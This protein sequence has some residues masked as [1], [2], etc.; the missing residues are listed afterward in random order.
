MDYFHIRELNEGAEALKSSAKIILLGSYNPNQNEK[1]IH[2]PIC[3]D[4]E[5]FEKC[6]E[7]ISA[8]CEV[9]LNDLLSAQSQ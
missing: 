8:S 3:G 1:V 9:F 7:Q 5:V 4:R 2:D 6:Y